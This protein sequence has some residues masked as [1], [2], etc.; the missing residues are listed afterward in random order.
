MTESIAL[1]YDPVEDRL[2][3]TT[4][5]AGGGAR[6]LHLT[7]RFTRVLVRTLERMANETAGPPEQGDV[8]QRGNLAALH[9]DALAEQT[10]IEP[11]TVRRPSSAEGERPLLVTGVRSGR[12]RTGTVRWVLEFACEGGAKIRLTLSPRMLHAFIERLRRRLPRTDWGIEL[13]PAPKNERHR[14]LMH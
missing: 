10:R 5:S 2:A 4:T 14:A 12:T 3:L 7:R 13:L 8:G 9:H 6:V 1:G 11:R